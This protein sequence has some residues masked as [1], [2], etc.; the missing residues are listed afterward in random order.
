MALSAVVYAQDLEAMSVFYAD[1]FDL[2]RVDGDDAHT[3]LSDGESSLVVHAISEPGT[4]D[5]SAGPRE[6]A[7]VK[8]SIPVRDIDHAV[9]MAE[10]LGGRLED[11]GWSWHGRP[12]YSGV[13]PE[14]NVI[15]SLQ[16]G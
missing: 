14:G 9:R 3:E 11:A 1:V 4:I 5:T 8:I 13:D 2:R 7:A 16:V 6:A 12:V 10:R 15:Q